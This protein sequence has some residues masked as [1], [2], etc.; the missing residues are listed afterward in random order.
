[1]RKTKSVAIASTGK[2]MGQSNECRKQVYTKFSNPMP[3]R[4]QIYSIKEIK[5][6]KDQIIIK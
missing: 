5:N 4:K 3:H 1:M 6:C 2:G